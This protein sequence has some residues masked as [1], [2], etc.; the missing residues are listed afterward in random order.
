M[1]RPMDDDLRQSFA[2][3]FLAA[4]PNSDETD[5]NTAG[6]DMSV[7]LRVLRER[8]PHCG[9][10]KLW[11]VPRRSCPTGNVRI[12]FCRS[13]QPTASSHLALECLLFPKIVRILL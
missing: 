8:R 5:Y 12:R 3:H 9:V 4:L 1:L 11:R 7:R 2:A 6:C 10:S 13:R